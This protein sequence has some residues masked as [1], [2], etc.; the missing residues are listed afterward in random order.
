[1]TRKRSKSG[2]SNC[3]HVAAKKNSSSQ[4]EWG[5]A[6]SGVS[7]WL[8]F[9]GSALHFYEGLKTLIGHCSSS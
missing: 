1:M 7:R 8:M 4:L 5:T 6:I 9:S 2:L 3:S